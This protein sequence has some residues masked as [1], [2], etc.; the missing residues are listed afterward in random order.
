MMAGVAT[1]TIVESTRI[2]KK[3]ITSDH[4]AGQGRRSPD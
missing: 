4:S 2:M 3:P 1:E